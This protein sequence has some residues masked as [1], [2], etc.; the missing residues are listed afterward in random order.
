MATLC[1]REPSYA[2]YHAFVAISMT[3]DLISAVAES[4]LL[5]L[6]S[7]VVHLTVPVAAPVRVLSCLIFTAILVPVVFDRLPVRWALKSCQNSSDP[8]NSPG[9]LNMYP[10]IWYQQQILKDLPVG[11]GG[12]HWSIISQILEAMPDIHGG[13]ALNHPRR[14]RCQ[15][16]I[17]MIGGTQ[18]SQRITLPPPACLL[19]GFH[20]VTC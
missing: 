19:L 6:G 10:G 15:S 16:N 5:V 1:H 14:G 2:W 13:S 8:S 18:D 4:Y 20:V 12:L 9:P 11:K 3:Y 7:A 17:T